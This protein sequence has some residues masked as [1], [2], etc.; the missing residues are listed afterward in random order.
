MSVITEEVQGVKGAPSRGPSAN[1]LRQG[2]ANFS[3]KGLVNMLGFHYFK[4][5]GPYMVSLL[6]HISFSS[7]FSSFKIL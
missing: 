3:V 1:D 5:E 2:L 6:L 4:I 7:S